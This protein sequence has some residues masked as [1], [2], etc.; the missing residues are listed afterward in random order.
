MQDLLKDILSSS[1][2][3]N[4][5]VFW[6][7]RPSLCHSGVFL[8]ITSELTL[9][10]FHMDVTNTYTKESSNLLTQHASSLRNKAKQFRLIFEGKNTQGSLLMHHFCHIFIKKISVVANVYV[11]AN[12]TQY[13]V[14]NCLQLVI[15]W[16]LHTLHW[17]VNKDFCTWYTLIVC[18]FIS[19][20]DTS[21]VWSSPRNLWIEGSNPGGNYTSFS[22][23]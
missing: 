4:L 10:I 1:N 18:P 5:R 23:T 16:Q 13:F 8:K 14:R 22:V 19:K 3:G 2:L 7:E 21:A 17:F 20:S 15:F 6:P 9:K 12:F 11:A